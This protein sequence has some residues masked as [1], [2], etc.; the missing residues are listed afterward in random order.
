MLMDLPVER[1]PWE[2]LP[3]SSV[4]AELRAA[5]AFDAG[6]VWPFAFGGDPLG[7]SSGARHDMA[8]VAAPPGEAR[9][10]S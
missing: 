8:H 5:G 3:A 2:R 6:G 1:V 7:H 4:G 10:A 9:L